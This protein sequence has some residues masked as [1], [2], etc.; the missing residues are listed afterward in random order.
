MVI[1]IIGILAALGS[2]AAFKAL[3]TA[4]SARIT[5]EIQNLD[6]AMKAYKEKFGDY[7]PCYYDPSKPTSVTAIKRHLAKAFDR[8]D[9]NAEV[10]ALKNA[11]PANTILYPSEMLVF[12][13][14]SMSKDPAHPIS[15]NVDSSQ[16]YSFFDFDK[17]RI[18]PISAPT[19]NPA[20]G[21]LVGGGASPTPTYT[22]QV[23]HPA[24]LTAPYVYFDYNYYL[25]PTITSAPYKPLLFSNTQLGGGKGGTCMP[26]LW[27]DDNDNTFDDWVN[28]KS[29]QI[30]SAGLDDDY[31]TPLTA[32]VPGEKNNPISNAVGNSSLTIQGKLYP[33]G[34]NYDTNGADDDNLTNFA[35]G[36]LGDQKP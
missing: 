11:L 31:G 33:D 36:K 32:N 22:P 21:W 8:C 24:N 28:P 27:D 14:T 20:G 30:I 19:T 13:L 18:T 6:A 10:T 7:P 3:E 35:P 26:Y 17:S 4:K 12:W 1:T 34:T 23:Y 5:A 29:C 16:R 25:D 9:P 2:V 15:A